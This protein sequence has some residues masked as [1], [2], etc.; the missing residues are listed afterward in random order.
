M[1]DHRAFLWR[2][3][4][5]VVLAASISALPFADYAAAEA[6]HHFLVGE[7]SVEH[8]DSY[9]LGLSDPAD[10]AHARDLIRLGPDAAGE[11]IVVAKAAMGRDGINRNYVIPGAPLWSWHVAEFIS[12]ADTT[13]E[14]LDAGPRNLGNYEDDPEYSCCKMMGFWNY[15]VVAEFPRGD[16]DDDTDIDH[17]DVAVWRTTYGSDSDLRADGNGDGIVDTADYLMWRKNYGSRITIPP[18]LLP[19]TTGASIIVP[20]PA[21][22]ALVLMTV[23]LCITWW[24]TRS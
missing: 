14:I 4:C 24:R 18:H 20:E 13:A 10:I 23:S 11:T 3:V 9:V 17:F 5:C 15:T 8:Y 6:T 22:P 19:P 16:Y 7:I 2:F 12:F 21:S 1:C